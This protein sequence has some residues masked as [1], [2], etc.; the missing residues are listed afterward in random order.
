[1]FRF[2][3]AGR[4]PLDPGRIPGGVEYI[5]YV[6]AEAFAERDDI[7]FHVVSPAKDVR[8]VETVERGRLRIHYVGSPC[9]ALVPNMLSQVSPLASVI[10]E[11]APDAVNSHHIVTT[12][13]AEMA[14]VRVLHTIHGVAKRELVHM[15]GRHLV[16]GLLQC[17]MDSKYIK[18]ANAVMSVAQYGLDQF[19]HEVGSRGHVVPVPIEDVFFAVP[20]VKPSSGLLYVGSVHKRKNLLALLKAMKVVHETHPEAV[21][22]VCGSLAHDDY[23]RR[24]RA[25]VTQNGLD[26]S[27][28]LLGVVD[29]KTI[30]GL[31]AESICL[32]LPS[33]QETSPVVICQAMASG[34]PVVVSPVGGIPDLVT[35]GETGFLVDADDS[36]AIADRL[37]R[38]LNDFDLAKRMGAAARAVAKRHDRRQVADRILDICRSLAE[39]R[40]LQAPPPAL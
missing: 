7:D 25:F 37:I 5:M 19:R 1:M 29:R 27:V 2:V 33:K 13:A 18:R 28:R 38:L 10:R 4:Y 35:D 24:V 11:L 6:L 21:L 23:Y 9:R 40:S 17:Y 20:D 12:A 32:A 16:G 36:E 3:L 8:A 15:S 14:G 22:H 39:D 34:R 31:L 30:T 26:H